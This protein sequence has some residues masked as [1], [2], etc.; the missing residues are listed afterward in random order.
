MNIM[1]VAKAVAPECRT[2]IIGVRPGEKL[3]EIMITPDD[4]WNTVELGR[5]Y[6]IQPAADWWDSKAYVDNTHARRVPD[7]FQYSSDQ[8]TEWMSADDLQMLLKR[9]TVEGGFRRAAITLTRPMLRPLSRCFAT[10]R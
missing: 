9:E 2:E 3:H 5:Y 8:N 6:V 7:G 1:D 10:G 4:A